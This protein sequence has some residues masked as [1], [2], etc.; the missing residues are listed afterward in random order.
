MKTGLWNC[1]MIEVSLEDA[2]RIVL[3][4]QGLRTD[5]PCKSVLEAARRIHNTQIVIYTKYI[6]LR[7]RAIWAQYRTSAS[8]Q[9]LRRDIH[10]L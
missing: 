5:N 3:D 10:F 6:T 7:N 4:A 9:R 8:K 2:R 1:D